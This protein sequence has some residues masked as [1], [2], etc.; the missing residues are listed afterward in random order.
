MRINKLVKCPFCGGRGEIK[1]YDGEV[2]EIHK[3]LIRCKK[4]HA[5]VGPINYDWPYIVFNGEL[6]KNFNKDEAIAALVK[7]WNTRISA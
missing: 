1:Y 4:C 2:T 3:A 6:N 7:L 5:M